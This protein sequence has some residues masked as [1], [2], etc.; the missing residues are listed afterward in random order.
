MEGFSLRLQTH[1]PK[2]FPDMQ[3]QLFI[4]ASLPPKL[5]VNPNGLNLIFVLDTQAFA[6]LPNSSLDPLFLLE[7]VS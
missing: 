6:I 1:G 5:T 4:W 3:M 7:M 2:M